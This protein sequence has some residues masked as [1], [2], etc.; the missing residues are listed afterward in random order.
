MDN[1]NWMQLFAEGAEGGTEGTPV[2]GGAAA[3]AAESGTQAHW[4]RVD[5][6][7]DGIVREAESLRELFP[8][9]DLR[10]EARNE[11]FCNLLRGGA[12]GPLRPG[13]H[14]AARYDTE[15]F[16]V[17]EPLDP[18]RLARALAALSPRGARGQIRVDTNFRETLIYSAFPAWGRMPQHEQRRKSLICESYRGRVPR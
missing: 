18:E 7:Y 4:Q 11:L 3:P 6:T 16:S 8:D 14:A 15:S 2:E 1:N 5:Q 10:R 12:D 9:L 13:A 17:E